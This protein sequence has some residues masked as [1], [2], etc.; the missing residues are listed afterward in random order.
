M[1][2]RVKGPSDHCSSVLAMTSAAYLPGRRS[3]ARSRP[4]PRQ[5]SN[6]CAE[7][8]LAQ[9]FP[10]TSSETTCAFF[11]SA[12]STRAPS[13]WVHGPHRRPLPRRPGS[14]STSSS[15]NQC[16]SR[17]W[18]SRSLR[19][20]VR[21]AFTDGDHPG[22][23]GLS[24]SPVRRWTEGG[25]QPAFTRVSVSMA[26]SSPALS[27]TSTAAPRVE[28]AHPRQHYVD[29]DIAQ[30][31]NPI[32]L[33]LAFHAQRLHVEFFA[34]RTT[35]SAIDLTCG[36]GPRSDHHEVGDAALSADIDLDGVA[37]LEFL[38]RGMHGLEHT[39]VGGGGLGRRVLMTWLAWSRVSALMEVG[40]L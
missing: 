2:G 16:D 19:N 13:S 26:C 25:L 21:C 30:S 4:C 11:G 1:C 34:N 28:L 33:A 35:S 31:T 24:P 40:E 38:D 15:G 14:I 36:G 37:G 29:H 10:R 7:C 6:R 27:P 22:F 32:G 3:K 39:S 5:C 12:D 18:Y 17:F 20:P 8:S 23:H 9:G